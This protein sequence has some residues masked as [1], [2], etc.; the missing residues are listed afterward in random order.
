MNTNTTPF[1]TTR[2]QVAAG[3]LAVMFTISMLV[4]VNQLATPSAADQQMAAAA[5]ASAAAG[6]S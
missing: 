4:G 3:A 2:Q 6:K 5:A 1:I